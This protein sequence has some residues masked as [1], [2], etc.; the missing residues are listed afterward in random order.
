MSDKL[1]VPAIATGAIFR[2][3]IGKDTAMGKQVADSKNSGLLV[4]DP[5][6]IGRRGTLEREKD[7]ERVSSL[8]YPRSLVQENTR[9]QVRTM[10]DLDAAGVVIE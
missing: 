3:P 9:F 1:G 4:P 2:T 6:T 8:R 5:L 10:P 7:C